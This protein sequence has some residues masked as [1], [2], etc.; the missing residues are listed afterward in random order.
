MARSAVTEADAT[1]SVAVVRREPP[2]GRF[3]DPSPVSLG[4]LLRVD[5][6]VDLLRALAPSRA[7]R[8][9]CGLRRGNS[10]RRTDRLPVHYQFVLAGPTAGVRAP[11]APRCRPR[12]HAAVHA[13]AVGAFHA[14]ALV[15]VVLADRL[16]GTA[17]VARPM[18][19]GTTA[20]RL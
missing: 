17:A 6:R 5:C 8:R 10:L 18:A 14:A 4:A 19:V 20:R 11:G 9:R 13:P 2:C 16:L 3:G 7:P 15:R 12:R 1:R